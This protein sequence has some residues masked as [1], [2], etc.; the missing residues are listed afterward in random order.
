MPLVVFSF[1]IRVGTI[2]E[3]GMSQSRY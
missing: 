3:Q 2:T 1:L